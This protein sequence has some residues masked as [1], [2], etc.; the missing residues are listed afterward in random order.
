M[1]WG[2]L[3][4]LWWCS[5][6]IAGG[7]QDRAEVD[8]LLNEM[9][10]LA[11]RGAWDGV[12]RAYRSLV[13]ASGNAAAPV[14]AHVLGAHAAQSAGSMNDTWDRLQHAAA[15]APTTETA[16]WLARIFAN[17][18]EVDLRA[19]GTWRGLILLESLDPVFAP[20]ATQTLEAARADLLDVRA[21]QGLL[22]LG[23]YRLGGQ[24]F[25]IVG[26]PR[27]AVVL[28][29]GS[30]PTELP[31]EAPAVL[32]P[33]AEVPM[34]A[35][36]ADFDV[37]PNTPMDTLGWREIAVALR[38]DLL[39]L[40]EV[41]HVEIT[42]D[43]ESLTIILTRPGMG[44]LQSNPDALAPILAERLAATQVTVLAGRITLLGS[45]PADAVVAAMEV[46][47]GDGGRSGPLSEVALIERPGP[48]APQQ[49][50]VVAA[51]G[52]D[53]NSLGEGV[54]SAIAVVGTEL[55]ALTELPRGRPM[56]WGALP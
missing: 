33:T 48:E 19:A 42:G 9:R 24:A 54:R 5:L 2:T 6:A 7:A 3:V 22:P 1:W 41:D 18:G 45:F 47:A 35:P 13:V 49:V 39:G 16:E 26:G 38:R 55:L 4:W 27:V 52:S 40:T 50:H 17:Y 37:R 11:S 29:N 32:L 10:A 36:S 25:D 51:A 56:I 8:R 14:E 44:R 46:P 20:D 23:R 34:A 43:V 30:G 21:Y 15:I 28:R 31:A 53:G 12:D